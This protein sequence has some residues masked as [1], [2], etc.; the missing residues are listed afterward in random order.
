MIEKIVLKMTVSDDKQKHQSQLMV[1]NWDVLIVY[2]IININY[3]ENIV[4][5]DEFIV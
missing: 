5:C 3:V 2:M 4:L 1:I